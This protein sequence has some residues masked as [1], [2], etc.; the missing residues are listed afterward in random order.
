[1]LSKSSA[2]NRSA[3]TAAREKSEDL[4]HRPEKAKSYHKL[5]P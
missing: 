4:T 3:V 2:S 5:L 1:M